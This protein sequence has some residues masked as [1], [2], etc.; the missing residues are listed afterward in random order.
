MV[1][2]ENR[3]LGTDGLSGVDLEKMTADA[4]QMSV[5]EREHAQQIFE[6]LAFLEAAGPM[7]PGT[8]PEGAE[9]R[10]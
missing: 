2:D 1:A 7:I 9:R 6:R 5:E 10:T 8:N 4:A 3:P